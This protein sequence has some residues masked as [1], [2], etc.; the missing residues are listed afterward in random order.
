MKALSSRT[1]KYNE[2]TANKLSSAIVL[3]VYKCDFNFGLN[4]HLTEF[5]LRIDDNSSSAGVCWLYDTAAIDCCLQEHCQF[6]VKVDMYAFG[7]SIDVSK[8]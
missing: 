4:A 1:E 2:L 5:V 6:M 3:F 8:K 7:E